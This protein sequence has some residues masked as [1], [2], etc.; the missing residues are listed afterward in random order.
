M[1]P[2][3]RTYIS[4]GLSAMIA[5]SVLAACSPKENTASELN[6]V[7]TGSVES[8]GETAVSAEG[9]TKGQ[10]VYVTSETLHLRTSPKVEDSNIA[11]DAKLNDQ[12]E[13]LDAAPVGENSFVPVRVISASDAS[14]NGKTLYTSIRYLSLTQ[15]QHFASASASATGGEDRFVIVNVATEM[16]RLYR[17]CHAPE[18][19]K[20]KMLMQFHGTV[21]NNSDGMRSDVGTYKTTHWTKFYEDRPEYAGWYRPGYPALPKIGSRGAWIS[22]SASPPGFT[23]TRGAFGWYTVFVGPNNDGQWM[24]GTIGWGEDK[25]NFVRFQDS[26]LGGIVGIF[27]KLGSHGCTRL[28]NEAIAYMRSNYPVGS[29]LM[30]V[31]AREAVK[32]PSLAGYP[33]AG[34]LGHFPYILTT[35]GYGKNNSAHEVAARDVVIADG[36]PSTEYLDQGTFDYIQTPSIASGD[37]YHLGDMQGVLNVDEGTMSSDYKIPV[38]DKL[39][40]G[41]YSGRESAIPAFARSEDDSSKSVTKIHGQQVDTSDEDAPAARPAPVAA[42]VVPAAAPVEA[43]APAEQAAPAASALP[44]VVPVAQPQAPKLSDEGDDDQN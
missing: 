8:E 30:K 26:F 15:E 9:I 42:P 5:A 38:S 12:L 27:A 11:G 25:S 39:H 37:H 28:S 10:K 4:R 3:L 29:Y 19:C 22:H 7:N 44:A 31:Y 40:V 13:V 18:A 24:H 6:P 21:G 33:K 35:V 23:S 36:T 1:R 14:L 34:D 41:G 16:I 20:N 17:R 43:P 2:V 32:D